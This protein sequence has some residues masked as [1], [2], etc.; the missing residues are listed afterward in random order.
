MNVSSKKILYSLSVLGVKPS[1][2]INFYR[3]EGYDF[4][5]TLKNISGGG[6]DG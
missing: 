3:T 1:G 5:K 6:I 4:T 2:F